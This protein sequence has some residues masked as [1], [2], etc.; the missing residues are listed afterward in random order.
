LPD[1]NDGCLTVSLGSIYYM[2]IDFQQLKDSIQNNL[3]YIIS[4]LCPGGKLIGREYVAATIHGGVG[5]SFS[6]NIETG[7][8]SDF[9]ADQKGGDV[10]SLKAAQDNI[11]QIEAA[12]LIM[13]KYTTMDSDVKP[14]IKKPEVAIIPPPPNIAPPDLTSASMN[15]KYTD[16]KGNHL[17][18]VARYNHP[19]GSK[20]FA[21]FSWDGSKWIKRAYP[22][23]RPMYKLSVLYKSSNVLI[24]EGEKACDAAQQIV[25]DKYVCVSWSNG[26]QSWNK[27]DWSPLRNKNVLI[28]PDSDKTGVDTAYKIAE[29]LKQYC[30]VIKVIKVNPD[31]M[32]WDAADALD[33]GFDWTKLVSW[34]K[35][36]I[37]IVHGEVEPI[38][39]EVQ[40]VTLLD[41]DDD[42]SLIDVDLRTASQEEIHTAL[43]LA[44]TG[45]HVVIPNLDNCAR[46]FERMQNFKGCVWF[47]DFHR[48][49]FT[50]TPEHGSKSNIVREW[51]DYDD[52]RLTK[53]LQRVVGINRISLGIV[54][55][56]LREFAFNDRRNEPRDWM[57]S[58]S[59]DKQPRIDRF[60]VDAL[61][62]KES[63]Y[64]ISASKNFWLSMPARIFR[65]GCQFDNMVVFEGKQGA[66]KT[67]AMRLIGGPWH[68]EAQENVTSKDFFMILHGKLL[69]EIA[70]LSSFPRSEILRIKQVISCLSDRYRSPYERSTADHPRMSIFVAT[71]NENKYLHDVTGGRR[72]WPVECGN[73]DLGYIKEFRE[74]LFA[75]AVFRFK[76]NEPWHIMPIEETMEQQESRRQNDVWEDLI[77]DYCR[78][79]DSVTVN[80]V[81]ASLG[82]E[83]AKLDMTIQRR[84]GTI[85]IQLGFVYLKGQ[86]VKTPK[87]RVAEMHS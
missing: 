11:T 46:V 80:E 13:E 64:S 83:K 30:R 61:G 33:E 74:Q 17:F 19:D 15:W 16:Q 72:F 1:V 26:A 20:S 66:G 10:I 50:T 12:R 78:F 67:S 85:L 18:Y 7:L 4:D 84:I 86:W 40:S 79:K 25:E 60:F 14:I 31:R 21:P 32:G 23:P 62:V 35:P 56:A 45:N 48:K 63:N 77:G 51:N 52:M 54:Q 38:K 22:A 37:D 75:E 81:S 24:T 68:C 39:P 8:W 59:W 76:K 29:H 2:T 36:Q 69:V 34:A 71:T 6:F 53:K 44:L 47:D 58:L 27:T 87:A 65:P 55:T 42:I 73:I 5:K 3:G 28:W 49:F 57:E 82:I 41:D 9:S 43:G 70:E